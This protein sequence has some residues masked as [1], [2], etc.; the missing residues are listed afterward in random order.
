M[1]PDIIVHLN[2]VRTWY[3]WVFAQFNANSN[4]SYCRPDLISDCNQHVLLQNIIM[5]NIHNFHLQGPDKGLLFEDYFAALH[6][7]LD[8]L[9]QYIATKLIV[10]L[11]AQGPLLGAPAI[12][13][14][15]WLRKCS[16][17]SH[18]SKF[19]WN[20]IMQHKKYQNIFY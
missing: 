3:Y 13:L 8:W 20:G 2:M 12:S 17:S 9:C 19:A 10:V 15:I 4:L 7:K 5:S 1:W 11:F 14:S 18:K 16:I 6:W